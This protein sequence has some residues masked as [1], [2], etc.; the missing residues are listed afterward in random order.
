MHLLSME[1]LKKYFVCPIVHILNFVFDF[2]DVL[3]FISL[4]AFY[5]LQLEVF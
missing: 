1:N 2:Y 5:Q 3:F 4:V